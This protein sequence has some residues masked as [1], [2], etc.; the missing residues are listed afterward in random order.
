MNDV[1]DM[2]FLKQAPNHKKPTSMAAHEMIMRN[3]GL[4]QTKARQP[5]PEGIK[6]LQSMYENALTLRVADTHTISL[7][8]CCACAV[9]DIRESAH[10]STGIFQGTHSDC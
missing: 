5:L 3:I 7:D 1:D 6:Y 4:K 9:L 8:E 2:G 10:R